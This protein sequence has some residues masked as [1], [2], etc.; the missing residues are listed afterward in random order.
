MVMEGL[1]NLGEGSGLPFLSILLP[2]D[3]Q[4]WTNHQ[5]SAE[6]ILGSTEVLIA[7]TS[8]MVL[9]LED[10]SNNPSRDSEA[11]TKGFPNLVFTCNTYFLGFFNGIA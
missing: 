11:Y 7:R 9:G 2:S 8:G 1:L 5:Q 6:E 4:T 3:L 10:F